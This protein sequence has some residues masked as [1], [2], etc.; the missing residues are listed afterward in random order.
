MKEGKSSALQH[1]MARRLKIRRVC[2]QAH[3]LGLVGKPER[4]QYEA[5]TGG[6]E[7]NAGVI[8]KVYFMNGNNRTGSGAARARGFAALFA[9]L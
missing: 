9:V 3:P 5:E 2:F 4:E 6:L 8:G 1:R 7:N